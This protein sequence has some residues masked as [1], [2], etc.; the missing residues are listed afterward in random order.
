MDTLTKQGQLILCP[1]PIGNLGDISRRVLETL[2]QADVIAAEDTRTS[3]PLLSHFDIHTPLIS[4]HK[5]NEQE[6]SHELLERVKRG[7]TVALISDAGMP[8]ISD[9][10][11]ILVKKAR[12]LGLSVTALPGPSAFVT[13]L[14][15]S[16]LDSRRFIFEGFLPTDKDQRRLVLEEL[17]ESHHTTIFYEAPHRLKETLKLFAS[18]CP[19]RHGAVVREITK[20]FEEC[21]T[22]TLAE[23]SDYFSEN[24]PRG[25]FVILI[26]GRSL[27]SIKEEK[28]KS[29]EEMSIEE[30]MALYKDLPEKEA[31]KQ[32]ARDRGVSKRDIYALLKK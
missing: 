9:P 8:A 7:E 19:D 1:T 21:R 32:V 15:M 4:Y 31:M 18:V 17:S 27:S 16:G 26:E 22:G 14:A 28:Q 25:E 30:H 20:R 11:Q 29:F 23:L 2:Q 10:G 13:A 12:E 6:R 5:F 24:E 3:A